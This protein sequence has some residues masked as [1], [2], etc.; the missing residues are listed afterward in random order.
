MTRS[1]QQAV[2]RKLE[3]A[4]TEIDDKKAQYHLREC[5]QLLEHEATVRERKG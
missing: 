4:L 5:L 3:T 1:G 2:T